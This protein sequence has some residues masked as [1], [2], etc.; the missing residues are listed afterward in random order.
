MFLD[1]YLKSGML[2]LI[3][4]QFLSSVY[5]NIAFSKSFFNKILMTAD[6]IITV[7]AVNDDPIAVSLRI[8]VSECS[9]FG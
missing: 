7:G 1:A 4:H 2:P 3:I 8:P 5:N 9:G 6:E